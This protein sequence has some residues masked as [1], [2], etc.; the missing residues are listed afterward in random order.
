MS[1]AELLDQ[2]QQILGA[3]GVRP[4]VPVPAP[5]YSTAWA[6]GRGSGYAVPPL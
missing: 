1:A 3:V 6:I 2:A 4:T 5:R